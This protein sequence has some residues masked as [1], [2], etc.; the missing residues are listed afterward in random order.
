MIAEHIEQP[1]ELDPAKKQDT[2][3][4]QGARRALR[5]ALAHPR[6]TRLL[7]DERVRAYSLLAREVAAVLQTKAAF[8]QAEKAEAQLAEF[9]AAHPDI[10]EAEEQRRQARRALLARPLLAQAAEGW[11]RHRRNERAAVLPHRP[12]VVRA[13][14]AATPRNRESR[15]KAAAGSS[16][17]RGDPSRAKLRGPAAA[18]ED[19][20][21]CG[22]LYEPKD[23]RQ[24]Y[25]S[26]ACSNRTRQRRSYRKQHPPVANPQKRKP[27][28]LVGGRREEPDPDQ[29]FRDV[30]GSWVWWSEMTPHVWQGRKNRVLG[31]VA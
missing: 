14:A 20:E 28:V 10:A 12:V 25:C 15:P 27:L 16:A 23:P 7:R 26:P 1:T 5:F 3:E 11:V 18:R 8:A 19:C 6:N 31:A 9:E 21:G 30:D 29:G 17:S 2:L 24:R 4:E 22:Q 13:V